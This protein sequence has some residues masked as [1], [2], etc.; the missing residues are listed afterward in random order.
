[1]LHEG[2]LL[3]LELLGLLNL[4]AHQ[5]LPERDLRLE[6]VDKRHRGL[7]VLVAVHSDVKQLVQELFV[8]G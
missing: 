3:A 1:M 2:L 8:V 6:A 7:L 5:R 4:D